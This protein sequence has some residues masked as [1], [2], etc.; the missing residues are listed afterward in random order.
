METHA[1]QSRLTMIKL[2]SDLVLLAL[3]RATSLSLIISKI[4]FVI[5]IFL[6]FVN[7]LRGNVNPILFK[8][9]A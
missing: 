3:R 1:F 2:A 7:V 9:Y 6:N 5:H 8:I 4:S